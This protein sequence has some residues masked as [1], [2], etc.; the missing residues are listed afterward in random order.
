M[1]ELLFP[2]EWPGS[3]RNAGFRKLR[4]GYSTQF[5]E[6]PCHRGK[7]ADTYPGLRRRRR[8]GSFFLFLS[9]SSSSSSSM[10]PDRSTPVHT[11]AR[12]F[13][14]PGKKHSA[15]VERE[16]WPWYSADDARL[17]II[18]ERADLLFLLE[19]RNVKVQAFS[20][21]LVADRD[22]W[23]FPTDFQFG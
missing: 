5:F 4:H 22:A 11:R 12:V 21:S 20:Q 13:S 8:P 14:L 16:T 18:L 19:P 7:N 23:A 15:K 2:A 3:K 1:L 9:S 10:T 6:Y 17:A